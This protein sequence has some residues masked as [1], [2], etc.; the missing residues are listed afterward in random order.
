M[1]VASSDSVLSHWCKLFEN[2]QMAPLEFYTTIE[3]AVKR[4]EIPNIEISRVDW[5]ESGIF[6]ARREYLRISRGRHVFDICGAPFGTGFFVSSWLVRPQAAPWPLA[7]LLLSLGA[8]ISLAIFVRI[9]GFILG[10]PVFVIGFPLLFWGFVQIMKE[11]EGWD[12]SIVAIPILGPIYERVFRPE[13]YYKIDTTLMFQ[14]SVHN[15]VLEAVD[16]LTSG[17]GVRA[18]SELERKPALIH[19]AKGVGS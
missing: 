12:D 16:Q 14:Q 3:Q 17:K 15:A 6:S 11:K 13:T 2:L 1:A 18:L 9:F 5:S 4:R 8:F 19:F 7:L 10:L